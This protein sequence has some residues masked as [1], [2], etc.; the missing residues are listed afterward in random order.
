MGVASS[1]Q[2]AAEQ[3]SSLISMLFSPSPNVW[4]GGLRK[5]VFIFLNQEYVGD[6]D[7]ELYDDY[8]GFY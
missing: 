3:R 6:D 7:Y 2:A 4:E 1:R 5:V 8:N